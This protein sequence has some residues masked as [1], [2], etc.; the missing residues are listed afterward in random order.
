MPTAELPDDAP[1][2]DNDDADPTADVTLVREALGRLP[3]DRQ[4][5]LPL[6]Y[7]EG[8]EVAEMA[9]ILD[10]PPGTVKSRLYHARRQLKDIIE[11]MQ[12]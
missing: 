8:F 9:V 6:H 3:G 2:S 1:A 10:V 7:L 4:A 5:L 12:S 11:R